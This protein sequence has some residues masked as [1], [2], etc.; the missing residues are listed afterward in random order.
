MKPRAIEIDGDIARVTLTQGKFALID[1]ADVPLVEGVN[2]YAGRDGY[3]VRC[4]PGTRGNQVKVFLHRVIAGPAGNLFVDHINGDPLDNRRANLREAT[5]SQNQMNAR[6][7][8]GSASALK[9]VTWNKAVG[10]WQ[11]QI[12]RDKRQVYLGLFESETAAHDA[13]CAAAAELHGE[14]ARFDTPEP[15]P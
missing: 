5:N 8:K 14:F 13:Y 12:K 11:A 1:R 2:W 3:A 15:R 4:L 9:G 7:R 10:K 6:K